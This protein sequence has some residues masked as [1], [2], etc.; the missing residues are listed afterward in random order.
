MPE[1]TSQIEVIVRQHLANITEVPGESICTSDRLVDDLDA[2]GDDLSFLFIPGVE[3]ELGVKVA[4]EV[5]KKVFTVQD[6]VAV[7]HTALQKQQTPA[8]ES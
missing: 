5:W 7:L 6:V 1:S 2:D 3:Q 8:R 4:P